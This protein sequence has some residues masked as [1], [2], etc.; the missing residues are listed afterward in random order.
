MKSD[1]MQTS[2]TFA[3]SPRPC[4]SRAAVP[5]IR[6]RWHPIK[7][8]TI[9]RQSYDTLARAYAQMMVSTQNGSM[10]RVAFEKAVFYR[11][12]CFTCALLA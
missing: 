12:C 9:A 3:G 11:R 1:D 4:R 6:T 5:A 2:Q 7:M 10:S 8:L